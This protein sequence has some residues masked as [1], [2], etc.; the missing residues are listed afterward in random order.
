MGSA[1]RQGWLWGTA[2]QDWAK[3][4]EPLALSLWEA[5]LD[6][7]AVGP[8]TRVLDAGCGAGGVELVED[9]R[10]LESSTEPTR[11]RQAPR[12]RTGP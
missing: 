1:T 10:R 2:T 5:M 12:N 9:R 7:A 8:D 3:L 6:A 11:S 4:Q